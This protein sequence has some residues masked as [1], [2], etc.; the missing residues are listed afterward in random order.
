VPRYWKDDSR[1]AVRWLSQAVPAGSTI[2][3]APDYVAGVLSHYA[4]LQRAPLRLVGADSVAWEG[5]RPAAL[6]LTRLHHVP[7]PESLR[8]RFR[9]LAGSGMRDDTV[10]GYEILLRIEDTARSPRR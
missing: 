6:M 7:N 9:E 10:G 3:T 5:V 4:G 1:G 8:N 2:L